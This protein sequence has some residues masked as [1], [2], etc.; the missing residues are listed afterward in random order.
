[1]NHP[2][3]WQSI[4]L[5]QAV[6]MGQLQNNFKE[7]SSTMKQK[8]IYSSQCNE[9]RKLFEDA[10]NSKKVLCVALDYA[11]DTHVALFCNGYGEILKKPFPVKN[12]LIGVAYL[13]E[14]IKKMGKARNIQLKHVFLGGEDGGPYGLNFIHALRKDGFIVVGVNAHDAKKQRDNMQAS[15]D[16]LDLLGIA[17][18]LLNRRGSVHSAQQGIY[19]N[20][21]NI[22]RYRRRMVQMKTSVSNQIH[23]QVQ[24]L[25]PGFLNESKSGIPPFSKSCLWL[26]SDHFSAQQISRRS[27]RV[28]IRKMREHGLSHAEQ[29]VKILKEYATTVL[30]ASN[31]YIHTLQVTLKHQVSLYQSLEECI[32]QSEQEIAC[33]LAQTPG[34]LLTTIRG[35]GVMLAAGLCAE[36][37]NPYQQH[38]V[39]NIVSYAGIIPRTAQSGGPEKETKTGSVAKRCNRILKDY[40]VQSANHIGQHGPD[41]LMTDYHR[42]ET[43][44]QHADFG[45]GRRYIRLAMHLMRHG[46]IYMPHAMRNHE[47]TKEERLAYYMKLWKLL[48]DKW[49]RVNALDGAF[50]KDTPLGQW[51]TM[52][53]ELYE[54][55]LA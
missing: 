49:H 7:R 30:C 38:P 27:L 2:L 4:V 23:A 9:V 29:K 25:F 54:V 13:K 34:A 21:R 33:L 53:K 35:I 15:S 47:T 39:K 6:C 12:T 32:T 37:G 46:E 17:K 55:T 50:H 48:K 45:M 31:E 5:I 40:V 26:L 3:S 44:S 11:K 42:R 14:R 51:R 1:M 36:L 8:S 24:Q 18:L 28:L 10:G 22:F 52:V 16:A 20:I 19:L 41:E 43:N